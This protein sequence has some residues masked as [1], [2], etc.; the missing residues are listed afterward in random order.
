MSL[1]KQLDLLKA[2]EASSGPSD[3]SQPGGDRL[4]EQQQDAG[5]L[6]RET[7]GLLSSL[8]GKA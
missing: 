6:G 8:A 3:G 2:A 7:G 4:R 5:S 1:E